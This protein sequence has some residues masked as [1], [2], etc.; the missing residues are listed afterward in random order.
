MNI[1]LL[2]HLFF[3][4]F[5]GFSRGWC[6]VLSF[7]TMHSGISHFKILLS[8]LFHRDFLVLGGDGDVIQAFG[9]NQYNVIKMW[10][11]EYPFNCY[12]FLY[13]LWI[14]FSSENPLLL[15]MNCHNF[16][17]YSYYI[18]VKIWCQTQFSTSMVHIC[19]FY[20]LYIFLQFL[21]MFID[22]NK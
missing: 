4:L 8:Y 1:S 5:L 3:S 17:I 16:S 21:K 2:N 19:V 11:R 10:R 12:L 7:Y 6:S 9:C 15:K 20:K 13:G 18:F 14:L 22:N